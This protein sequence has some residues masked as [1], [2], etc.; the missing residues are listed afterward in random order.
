MG[1]GGVGQVL[2]LTDK[3][4]RGLDPSMADVMCE[5]PL[6]RYLVVLKL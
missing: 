3:G 4:G 6:R 2:T 1:G 5:Q